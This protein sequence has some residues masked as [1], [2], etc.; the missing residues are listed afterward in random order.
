[1]TGSPRA[2]SLSKPRTTTVSDVSRETDMLPLANNVS[3][4]ALLFHIAVENVGCGFPVPVVILGNVVID[5]LPPV[6]A[7]R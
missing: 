7:G 6:K 2:G 5:E 4:A 3:M 1:M